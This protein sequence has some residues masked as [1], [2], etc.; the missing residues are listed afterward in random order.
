MELIVAHIS[1][2]SFVDLPI[3]TSCA[4]ALDMGQPSK[5]TKELIPIGCPWQSRELLTE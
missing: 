4:K 1:H 3:G 5:C 2:H